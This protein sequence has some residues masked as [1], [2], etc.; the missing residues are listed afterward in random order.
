M[1]DTLKSAT[2]MSITN[3]NRF[4]SFCLFAAFGFLINSS[5]RSYRSHV[6]DH[7]RYEPFHVAWSVIHSHKQRLTMSVSDDFCQ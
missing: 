7:L 5:I 3:S 1:T 4:A 6:I 2:G